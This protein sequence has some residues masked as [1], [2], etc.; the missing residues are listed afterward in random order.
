MG[1]SFFTNPRIIRKNLRLFPREHRYRR[2]C[3]ILKNFVED[4]K[5]YLAN[6]GSVENLGRHSIQKGAA[7]YCSSGSKLSLSIVSICLYSVWTISG[8]KERYL[9]YEN[10][11]DQFVSRLVCGL[12]PSSPEFSISPPYFETINKSEEK[13]V[14]DF[15]MGISGYELI[16]YISLSMIVIMMLAT[17]SFRYSWKRV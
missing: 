4:K 6:Y 7:S 13:E 8:S 14:S 9:K 17:I 2:H 1:V 10:D 11:G 5:E 12:N 15:F 16:S 3:Y